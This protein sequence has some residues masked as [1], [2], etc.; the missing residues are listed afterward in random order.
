M[1]EDLLPLLGINIEE[2]ESDS[3]DG[4]VSSTCFEVYVS[5]CIFR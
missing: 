5:F 4:N 2:N 1:A 3:E